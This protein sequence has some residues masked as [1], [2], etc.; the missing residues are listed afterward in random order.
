MELC[1]ENYPNT[2]ELEEDEDVIEFKVL[3]ERASLLEKLTQTPLKVTDLVGENLHKL[4]KLMSN[5]AEPTNND[6]RF[7]IQGLAVTLT[8]YKL[9]NL[10]GERYLKGNRSTDYFIEIRY[11]SN[12][13]KGINRTLQ[14]KRKTPTEI[15]KILYNSVINLLKNDNTL[16]DKD[17]QKLDSRKRIYNAIIKKFP[18]KYDDEKFIE[19]VSETGKSI[20][21]MKG[22]KI[23]EKIEEELSR[24]KNMPRKSLKQLETIEVAKAMVHEEEALRYMIAKT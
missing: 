9:K 1:Q 10:Q 5:K 16:S 12:I 23:R 14:S 4:E 13:L 21:S 11:L 3:P 18:M 6:L 8:A 15:S 20:E 2:D 24:Y 22:S 17:R 7:Q 19:H